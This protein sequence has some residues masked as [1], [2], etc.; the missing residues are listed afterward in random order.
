MNRLLANALTA[1]NSVLALMITLMGAAY[2][3]YNAGIPGILFG[4]AVGLVAAALACGFIA[5]VSLI[6]HHLRQISKALRAQPT[7]IEPKTDFT[8]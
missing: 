2:G 3:M 5:Y 8:E 4:G 1:L 6:E 7:K